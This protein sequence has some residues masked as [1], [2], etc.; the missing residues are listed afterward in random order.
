MADLSIDE[1]RSRIEAFD[2]RGIHPNARFGTASD[3]YAGWIGQIYP[4]SYLEEI[5]SRTLRTPMPARSRP[6]DG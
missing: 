1:R 3:R 2:F 4:D 5:S 6:P